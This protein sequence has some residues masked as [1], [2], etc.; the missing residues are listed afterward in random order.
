M[1][2]ACCIA[3]SLLSF[4]A[5][6]LSFTGSA[7]TASLL[8]VISSRGSAI[9]TVTVICLYRVIHIQLQTGII[10]FRVNIHRARINGAV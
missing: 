2:A 3:A 8:R 10:V 9:A 7:S 6:L 1:V 5:G 4:T